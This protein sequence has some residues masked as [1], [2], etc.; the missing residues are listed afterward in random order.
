MKVKIVERLL[1]MRKLVNDEYVLDQDRVIDM[2]SSVWG[3]V[4]ISVTIHHNDRVRIFGIVMTDDKNWY[5]YQ[6][7]TD[8]CTARHDIDDPSYSPIFPTMC[9]ILR[10]SMKLMHM[11]FQ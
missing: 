3:S 4:D 1:A 9:M 2:L 5:M 11:I 8:G 7:L 6:R 10:V